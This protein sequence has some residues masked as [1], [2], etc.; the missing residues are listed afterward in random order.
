VCK[1]LCRDI[2]VGKCSSLEDKEKSQ[3]K[4]EIVT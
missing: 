2:Q 4:I 3:G 1:S